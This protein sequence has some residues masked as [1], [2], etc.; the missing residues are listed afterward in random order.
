MDT[1][2]CTMDTIK[3]RIIAIVSI[4]KTI[5]S[6]VVKHKPPFYSTQLTQIFTN[7]L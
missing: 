7:D 4:V 3:K 6:I 1:M 5:V 2:G